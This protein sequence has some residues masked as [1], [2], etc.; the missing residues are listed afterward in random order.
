LN[1]TNK[2]TNILVAL[3]ETVKLID[4]ANE[5]VQGPYFTLSYVWGNPNLLLTLM[6]ATEADLRGGLPI[7]SLE[8]PYRDALVAT[9][10]LGCTYL[11]IDLFCIFQDKSKEGL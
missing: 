5:D 10:K 3:G 9:K 7:N 8:C 6:P 2:Q 4:T 11:W 1:Q